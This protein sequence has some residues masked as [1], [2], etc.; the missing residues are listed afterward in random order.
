MKNISIYVHIPFCMSKCSYC[1]FVSKCANEKEIKKYFNMLNVQILAESGLFKNKIITSIYFGGGTPSF[2]DSKYIAE[3]LKTI[4]QYYN[5]SENAEIT[6]ECN[7][8]S[9]TIEK[10]KN[11]KKFGINRISFGIQSLSDKCLKIIGR[12]HNKKMAI[13]AIKNAKNVGFLNISC[14]LLIGIPYQTTSILLN[15]IANLAKLGI[16]HISAYMLMLEEG[17]KLYEQV[18]INHSLTIADDDE[19]VNMYNKAYS[20]LTK[21][22]YKRYEISNFAL[23]G[24]ECKHN[25]NYWDMGEYVGFGLSAHSYYNGIRISRFYNFDD[26]YNYVREKYILRIKP[27]KLPEQ[28]LLTNQQKIEECLMLGLRQTKGVN[29]KILNNLGYNLIEVKKN[30]IKMLIS[31]NIIDCNDNYL[32]ITSN[33][34]G[35]TNQIILDLLPEI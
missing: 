34:F 24:Y 28:E 33:N 13:Q 2:V 22:G 14:D 3:V 27:N 32:Y 23:T 20:F 6:I 31:K 26:Y 9:T 30:T 5:V 10:L 35:A 11:Y 19:C 12:K 1:S 21:L 25:I 17:T 8:C 7:P 29:I 18:V 16:N 15:N 4:N